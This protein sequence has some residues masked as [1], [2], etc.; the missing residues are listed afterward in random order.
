MSPK[1]ETASP[2]SIRKAVLDNAGRL[3]TRMTG[4]KA[5]LTPDGKWINVYDHSD[6]LPYDQ[7][8]L[9]TSVPDM[10]KAGFVRVAWEQNMRGTSRSYTAGEGGML[11]AEYDRSTITP[12]QRAELKN[13]AIEKGGEVVYDP[14]YANFSP[15]ESNTDAL[16]KQVD[17]YAKQLDAMKQAGVEIPSETQAAFDEMKAKLNEVQQS[18]SSKADAKASI[19]SLMADANK[20]IAGLATNS[21]EA[22][23]ARQALADALGDEEAGND[24]RKVAEGRVSLRKAIERLVERVS[25][26]EQSSLLTVKKDIIRIVKARLPVDQRGKMLQHVAK[27]KNAD[28]IEEAVLAIDRYA[29]E[30][31]KGKLKDLIRKISEKAIDSPAVAVDYKQRIRELLDGVLLTKPTQATIDKVQATKDYIE[32]ELKAGREA[33]VPRRILDKLRILTATPAITMDVAELEDIVGELN[34]LAKQG[35]AKLDARK[36]LDAAQKEKDY[37]ALKAQGTRKIESADMEKGDLGELP[38][39]GMKMRNLLNASRDNLRKWYL[40]HTPTDRVFDILDNNLHY[41][42]IIFAMYKGRPGQAY[43]EF[44]RFM[45]PIEQEFKAII[46]K[47][48]IGKRESDRVGIYAV[49]KQRNGDDKNYGRK[50]IYNNYNAKT[51]AQKADIDRQIDA[52]VLTPDEQAYYD[53]MRQKMDEV[54]PMLAKAAKDIF[55]ADLDQVADYFPMKTDWDLQENEVLDGWTLDKD[56]QLIQKTPEDSM[57]KKRT[58]AGNQRVRTDS[59]K[60]FMK[61]MNDAYY[62]INMAP[63]TRY[64]NEFAKRADVKELVGDEGQRYLIDYVDTLARRGG[65]GGEH[66]IEWVDALRRN[67][68]VGTLGFRLSSIL[69]QPS[70]FIDSLGKVG[71]RWGLKGATN[72]MTDSK[73]RKFVFDNMQQVRDR[74]GDDP[75]YAESGALK[76]LNKATQYGY[77]PLEIFDRYTAAAVG[78]AAYEKYMHEHGLEVDLDKPNADALAEAELT[79]RLTQASGNFMDVPQV[80]SRG[81]GY[82]SKT[83]AKAIYQFQ[84]FTMNKFSYMAHDMIGY[85]VS[86]REWGKAFMMMLWAF[87]AYL[88]EEAVR[89]NLKVALGGERK[90]TDSILDEAMI[91]FATSVPI[92]GPI[93]NSTRYGSVPVPVVSTVQ[94]LQKSVSS[95]ATAKTPEGKERAGLSAAGALGTLAGIPGSGQVSQFFRTLIHSDSEKVGRLINDSAKRLPQTASAGLIALESQ[96]AYNRAKAQGLLNP[97]TT[98]AEFRARYKARFK[99]IN[100]P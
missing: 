64:L 80:V 38:T 8:P 97:K 49:A 100:A 54:R 30:H 47:H 51:D 71:P 98:P 58:G 22:D 11:H 60:A 28:D 18:E 24:A 86:D 15:K 48:K 27:A 6:A 62:L 41:R 40:W 50:K 78:A 29:E 61:H 5:W 53:F 46:E 67:V 70:S 81:K 43:A 85:G 12:M 56:H 35:K 10:T 4:T 94:N 59:A 23:E 89:A 7:V 44:R 34:L 92:L 36:A 45:F 13:T 95:L 88:T 52:I 68:G 32:S 26:G 93:I 17:D 21:A 1:S 84:T 75:A 77:L 55:N 66:I 39:W 69:I 33:E 76:W 79:V 82:N 57:M 16:K 9:D 2:D 87:M 72:I 91:D 96:K 90:K 31:Q 19:P 73:W 42:G 65:I 14:G 99:A 63:V 83:L 3:D 25:R 74:I 37:N 20:A